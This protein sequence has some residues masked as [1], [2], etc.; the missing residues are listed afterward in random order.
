MTISAYAGRLPQLRH[1]PG[2]NWV[3]ET[4]Y[5]LVDMRIRT[6]LGIFLALAMAP[7]GPLAIAA[8]SRG[9]DI[10]RHGLPLGLVQVGIALA[11]IVA[12]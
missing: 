5:S 7:V 8:L 11:W 9:R 10:W 1:P 4:L 6:L 2:L 3:A 12:A